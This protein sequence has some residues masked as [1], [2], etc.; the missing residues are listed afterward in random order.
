MSL[1]TLGRSDAILACDII[2]MMLNFNHIVD[3]AGLGHLSL[4]STAFWNDG[5]AE[6]LLQ[7]IRVQLD[8]IAEEEADIKLDP[9]KAEIL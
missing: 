7:F 2:D 1:V 9:T 3:Q 6:N 5:Q 8:S 4:K